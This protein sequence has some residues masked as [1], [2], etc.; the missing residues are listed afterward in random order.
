MLEHT[1]YCM[2]KQYFADADC[3]LATGSFLMNEAA[4][5]TGYFAPEDAPKTQA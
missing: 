3:P 5:W 4:I 2:N 1:I